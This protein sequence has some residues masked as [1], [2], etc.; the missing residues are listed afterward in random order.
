MR[1]VE[2]AAKIV[3]IFCQLQFT[4]PQFGCDRCSVVKKE[5]LILVESCY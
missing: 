4:L 2:M 5:E 3:L 1:I